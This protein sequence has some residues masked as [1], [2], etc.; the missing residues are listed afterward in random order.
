MDKQVVHRREVGGAQ[1]RTIEARSNGGRSALP[2]LCVMAVRHTGGPAD[3]CRVIW[4]TYSCPVTFLVTVQPKIDHE[5][6]R[7]RGGS[8]RSPPFQ[9]DTG[10]SLHVIGAGGP[11]S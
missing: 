7:V 2:P 11:P 3:G 10:S 6:Q 4:G 9:R 5:S 8:S 1:L